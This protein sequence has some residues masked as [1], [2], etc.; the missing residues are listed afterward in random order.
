MVVGFGGL[1]AFS[2]A[3]RFFIGMVLGYFLAGGAW[4]IVDTIT[5]KTL[6]AVFYI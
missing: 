5:G 2:T 3:R 4:N 6:N 1:G